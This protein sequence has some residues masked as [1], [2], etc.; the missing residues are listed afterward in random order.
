MTAVAASRDALAKALN[1][2]VEKIGPQDTN[3]PEDCEAIADALIASGAVVTGDILADDWSK[4][5]EMVE[6]H[7]RALAASLS[8]RR[9]A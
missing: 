2:T 6:N 4:W 8:E 1:A 7:I 9:Q 3:Y 5:R